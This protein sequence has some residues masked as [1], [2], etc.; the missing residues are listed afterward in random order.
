MSDINKILIIGS[1]GMLGSDLVKI[2][3]SDNNYNITEADMNNLDITN[4]DQVAEFI[5]NEKP[6]FVINAAAYTD[7]DKCE[8][9][10]DICNQVNGYAL[11]YLAKAC[12]D[13]D[14]KL[15]HISTDYVFNGNKKEGYKEEDTIDPVNQYG[16]SKAIGEDM[17]TNNMEEYY[18][19]RIS[20]LFGKSGKNFVETMLALGQDHDELK[21]VNDQHGK[22]TY[23]VDL[24]KAIKNLIEENQEYGVY[25][26][27]NEEETTWY[28][29]AKEIFELSDMKV[30]VIPCTSDE[31]PR[32]A[33]RPM[34]SSLL[35]TKFKKLR[36]WREAL[37]DYLNK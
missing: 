37:K 27:P 31:F 12:R 15:V 36:S 23:T 28:E 11:E 29:F 30:K 13:N 4:K 3:N 17:V 32:P 16:K 8:E 2:F 5:A 7:V 35:N 9:E 25:H 21:V 26:L 14:A 20:W 24:A 1:R 10:V 33:T 22:P 34:Y 6:D 19:I 18:I